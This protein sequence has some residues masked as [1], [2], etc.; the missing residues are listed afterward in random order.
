MEFI[1]I[2]IGALIIVS[3][4][5][6]FIRLIPTKGKAGEIIVAN[7][8]NHLPKNQYRVL[9]NITIPT[10]RGSSQIDHLVV[11]VFGIFVIETKNYNGWIY[12]GE[13][14][15]YWTQNIYGNKHQFYNPILQNAGHVKALRRVLIKYEPLFIFPIVAF[16]GRANI[17]VKIVDACIVYWGQLMSVILQFERRQLSWDQVN[18]ICNVIEAAQ[19]KPGKEADVRHLYDIHN[20]REQKY[21]A[22]VSGRCPR[23][24]GKLVL[25]SGQF[26]SFYG[27]SNY[28]KCRYT[29]PA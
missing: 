7:K 4:F 20:A 3:L 26:G 12:G 24:G 18:T 17:K 8:L 22:I 15:E 29:H 1:G 19:L 6:L 25:R 23:C 28:P 21:D 2:I 13:S 10:P 14:S 11:S 27:C 5:I 9:N 16:S